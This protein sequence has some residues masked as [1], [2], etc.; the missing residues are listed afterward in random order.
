M[1]LRCPRAPAV[2]TYNDCSESVTCRDSHF[3]SKRLTVLLHQHRPSKCLTS[4]ATAVLGCVS[5]PSKSRPYSPHALESWHCPPEAAKRSA[6]A[7]VSSHSPPPLPHRPHSTL[8]HRPATFVR[9][10]QTLPV[11]FPYRLPISDAP[12]AL[13]AQYL[14]NR[15]CWLTAWLAGCPAC[16]TDRPAK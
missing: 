11:R 3:P 2:H 8:R 7:N 1:D 16:P 9:S 12:A 10:S 15:G 6:S 13:T 14:S 5:G 4:G